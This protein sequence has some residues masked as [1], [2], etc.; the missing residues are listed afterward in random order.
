MG[1]EA[2]ATA[3]SPVLYVISCPI[4]GHEMLLR[5]ADSALRTRLGTRL[6]FDRNASCFRSDGV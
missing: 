6:R 1:D 2:A 4:M 5:L 3:A